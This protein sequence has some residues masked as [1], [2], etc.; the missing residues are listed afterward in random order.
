MPS[1]NMN[2]DAVQ[3]A[4]TLLEGPL[5]NAINAEGL[6]AAVGALGSHL[7]NILFHMKNEGLEHVVN[8][9]LSAIQQM[10]KTGK[11][12]VIPPPR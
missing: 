3:R 1:N 4:F 11:G 6:D 10:S 12:S 5:A 2:R 9:V 7:G 8:G